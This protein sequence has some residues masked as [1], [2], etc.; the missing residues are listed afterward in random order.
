MSMLMRSSSKRIELNFT[1]YTRNGVNLS[2]S[3]A[4]PRVK[5]VK[6]CY[7]KFQN[8]NKGFQMSNIC[9]FFA[10]LNLD[11]FRINKSLPKASQYVLLLL[12]FKRRNVLL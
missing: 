6:E 8:I 12:F 11:W 7:L 4:F 2:P 9:W 5:K 1:D 3:L 10:M